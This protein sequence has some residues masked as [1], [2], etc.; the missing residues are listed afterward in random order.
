[1]LTLPLIEL[2]ATDRSPSAATLTA[3]LCPESSIIRDISSYGH[4]IGYDR[5]DC[6]YATQVPHPR[7]VSNV[8]SGT[9]EEKPFVKVDVLL[10]TLRDGTVWMSD[11]W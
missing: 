7:L 4:A 9:C 6:I 5:L 3:D 10:I 8:M 1:M 2:A 11:E